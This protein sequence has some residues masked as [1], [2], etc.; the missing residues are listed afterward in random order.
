MISHDDFLNQRLSYFIS[1]I[2][3]FLAGHQAMTGHKP[4]NLMTKLAIY[5]EL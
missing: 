2:D 1:D 4:I 3:N 5:P